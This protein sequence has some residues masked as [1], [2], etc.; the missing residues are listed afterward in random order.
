[1]IYAEKILRLL[2]LFLVVFY[3]WICGCQPLGWLSV[4]LEIVC[5]LGTAESPVAA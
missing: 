4:V 1:M 3:A 5:P 2:C